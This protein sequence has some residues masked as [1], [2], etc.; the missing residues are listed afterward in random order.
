MPI[1]ALFIRHAPVGGER[2]HHIGLRAIKRMRA[3]GDGRGIAGDLGVEVT[4]QPSI[5]A[6]P[7]DALA[8]TTRPAIDLRRR[9]G[10]GRRTAAGVRKPPCRR[11]VPGILHGRVV[12]QRQAYDQ[13]VVISVS[14]AE[15]PMM[16]IS[17]VGVVEPEVIP[18]A[19]VSQLD[20]CPEP[21]GN[22]ARVEKARLL[23]KEQI[24]ILS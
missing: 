20:E 5:N 3:S 12:V 17:D 15:G 1:P 21:I 4:V 16:S 6:Q 24:A 10:P 13:A 14:T 9:Y 18:G 19:V 11:C 8:E 22:L 7:S 23:R 2:M